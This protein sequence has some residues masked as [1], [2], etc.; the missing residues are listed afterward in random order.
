MA[1]SRKLE[2][3]LA[4]LAEIR[5]APT[6]EAS[7]TTLRQVLKSK[8]S[9]AVAQSAK[10][11][12]EFAI[13]QL[14]PE[15]V[16]AFDRMMVNPSQTDPVCLAKK[17]IAEALYRLEYSE[18][19]LFLQGIQHVQMEAV[20]GGKEDTAASLRGVCALGLVRMHYPNVMSE[21]ADL[22]ADPKP[23][24][25]IAAARAI[26]YSENPEGSPLLRLRVRI[27]D[28]PQVISECLIALLKLAPAQSL[29]LLKHVLYAEHRETA[30]V[31][32]LALGESRL[33]EAFEILRN[34]WEQAYGSELRQTGLLAIAML[35]HDEA[36]EFLLSLLAD[37]K[38]SDAKDAIAALG[39]YRQDD[40]LWRRVC[41]LVEE[42]ANASLLKAI[43]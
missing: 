14:I 10:I 42:R 26:A 25:R 33:P 22:L 20:W 18:E 43:E 38:I 12:G 9:V 40:R 6:S 2:E 35:R 21:L 16:A 23:E 4:K 1:R 37:G 32:A 24:A 17:E 11:V 39:L 29:S 7:I 30:E 15:L 41:Q 28:E 8:N 3:T 19:S 31:A 13:A 34:W 36:L 27:G 5:D